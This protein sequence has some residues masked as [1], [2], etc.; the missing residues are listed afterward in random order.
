VPLLALVPQLL[1]PLQLVLV[2]LL[3]LVLKSEQKQHQKLIPMP[4]LIIIYSFTSPIYVKFHYMV[5]LNLQRTT[6]SN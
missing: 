4:R 5:K 3:A 1:V 2:P 6:Y